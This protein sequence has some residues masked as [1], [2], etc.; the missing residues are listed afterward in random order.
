MSA[1]DVRGGL[2]REG[3]CFI[4][5]LNP[6]CH[7]VDPTTRETGEFG[8]NDRKLACKSAQQTF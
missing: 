2:G 3:G 6:C 8:V 4:P 7:L 5:L 1:L